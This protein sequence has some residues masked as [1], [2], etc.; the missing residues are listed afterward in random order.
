MA[1]HISVISLVVPVKSLLCAL[2]IFGISE[3]FYLFTF[4][5]DVDIEAEIRA[6]QLDSAGNS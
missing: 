3:L 6:L 5:N 1:L 4:V 2:V